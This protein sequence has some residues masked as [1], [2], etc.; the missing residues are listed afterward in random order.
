MAGTPIR[1]PTFNDWPSLFCPHWLPDKATAL[2]VPDGATRYVVR[3]ATWG[4]PPS[5]FEAT[6]PGI[7]GQMPELV[8]AWSWVV[9]ASAHWDDASQRII[10][11]FVCEEEEPGS[12]EQTAEITADY[13]DRLIFA[14][15]GDATFGQTAILKVFAS[16]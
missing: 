7:A 14:E 13:V 9:A 10:M 15:V 5:L 4:E 6:T 2:Q 3:L 1:E 12:P 8:E 16:E 11:H